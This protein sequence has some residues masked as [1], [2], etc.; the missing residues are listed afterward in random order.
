MCFKRKCSLLSIAQKSKKI[1]IQIK[2][3]L[4]LET[5]DFHEGSDIYFAGER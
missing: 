5:R 1:Q 2:S 3:A 4:D